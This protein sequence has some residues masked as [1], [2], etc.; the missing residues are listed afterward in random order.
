MTSRGAAPTGVVVDRRPGDHRDWPQEAD[1]RRHLPR[2]LCGAH[3]LGQARGADCAGAWRV[4][5]APCRTP[6]AV[7]NP[8]PWRR[9]NSGRFVVLWLAF[10][11]RRYLRA[12]PKRAMQEPSDN[13]QGEKDASGA[14]WALARRAFRAVPKR[15]STGLLSG[16]VTRQK[17]FRPDPFGQTRWRSERDSNSR[18]LS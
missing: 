5:S 4:A 12:P 17:C 10:R 15:V 1:L 13:S 6:Q 11:L 16:P 18:S 14:G 3:A 2:S 7:S 9:R 8:S